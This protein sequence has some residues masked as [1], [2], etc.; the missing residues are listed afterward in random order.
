MSLDTAFEL[1]RLY[2]LIKNI[3]NQFMIQ[4][5]QI[6]THLPGVEG[7]FPGGT[8]D[9]SG[10]SVNLIDDGENLSETGSCEICYD[11]DAC[12]RVGDGVAY[13]SNSGGF[14][15]TG[16]ETYVEAGLRGLTM[17]GWFLVDIGPPSIP[18][19]MV[20]KY[21][22]ATDYGYVIL[23]QATDKMLFAVSGNGTT[24]VAVEA[25]TS[26]VDGEW[27]FIAARFTPSTEIAIFMDEEKD[28][29]TTSIPASLNVATEDF[30]V[31][32]YSGNNALIQEMLFRDLFICRAA[33]SDAL[34]ERIRQASLPL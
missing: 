12:R 22:P 33:L 30:E 26:P 7:Y 23:M 24:A 1:G 9:G 11:G 16:T 13:L 10:R 4:Q 8:V 28:V 17:G 19:G 21:G 31:G 15:I 3:S 27:H 29:E 2:P 25:S 14:D 5:K 6:F 20:G 32:R 34:V 18:A